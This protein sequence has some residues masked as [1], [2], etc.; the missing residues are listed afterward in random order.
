MKHRPIFYDTETTGLDPVKDRIIEIA[1][2]DPFL[3]KNFVTLVNPKIV[4]PQSSIDICNISNEMVK[5]APFFEEAG[6]MFID[7]CNSDPILIAHNNDSFDIHFL[8]NEFQR[9]GLIMPDW[10]FI[11]SLRWARKYRP[12]LPRHSLQYLREIYEIKANNAHRALDDVIVLHQVFSKMTD[13][14]DALTVYKLLEKKDKTLR[15]PFGKHQGK[16][17]SEVPKSY[18][19]WLLENGAFDKPENKS[20]KEELIKLKMIPQERL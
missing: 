6:K 10:I 14:L 5:D 1:A 17:L 4:I 15:M 13:D 16:S 8:R 11:D 3:N 19:S 12:D 2:Y 7:F 9:S 20:L 18:L